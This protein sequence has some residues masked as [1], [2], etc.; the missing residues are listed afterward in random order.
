MTDDEW[1]LER[2]LERAR[3]NTVG[4]V[5][6][7]NHVDERVRLGSAL[8]PATTLLEGGGVE[9]DRAVRATTRKVRSSQ[10]RTYRVDVVSAAVTS[11]SPPPAA[12][13][14]SHRAPGA[15]PQNRDGLVFH[16]S[17]NPSGGR[18][19]GTC[20]KPGPARPGPPSRRSVPDGGQHHVAAGHSLRRTGWPVGRGMAPRVY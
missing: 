10:P 11:S 2:R 19:S 14:L 4:D 1:I 20:G 9:A 15:A 16:P 7:G 12:W 18:V 5:V 8:I 6:A 13:P 17:A 3:K